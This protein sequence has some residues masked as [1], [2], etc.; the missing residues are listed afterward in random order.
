MRPRVAY[1]R[2]AAKDVIEQVAFGIVDFFKK[3]GVRH[4]EKQ[5]RLWGCRRRT[6]DIA[7]HDKVLHDNVLHGLA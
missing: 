2:V 6:G 7:R 1:W 5:R 3:V 4:T